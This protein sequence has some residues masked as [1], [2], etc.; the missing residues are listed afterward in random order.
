MR[1][2]K[3]SLSRVSLRQKVK[4][5]LGLEKRRIKK[6]G[7]FDYDY[8]QSQV[9]HKRFLSKDSTI[10]HYLQKGVFSGLNPNA[11]FDSDFYVAVYPEPISIG[12][13][14]FYH[15]I[16]VGRHEQRPCSGSKTFLQE[17][18]LKSMVVIDHGILAY[19]TNAGDRHI[20][21]YLELFKKMGFHVIY[22]PYTFSSADDLKYLDDLTSKGIET[23]V[24]EIKQFMHKWHPRIWEQWLIDN[25]LRFQLAVLSRPHVANAYGSLIQHSLCKPF[26]YFVIDL[27]YLR[28]F[29]SLSS[30][31]SLKTL[32]LVLKM[33]RLERRIC[34]KADHIFT[35]SYVES[36]LIRKK[37][38]PNVSDIPLFL[39]EKTGE[40]IQ[41]SKT[42][43]EFIF[44][45][46]FNHEP[47][48]LGLLW[49]IK[50]IMPRILKKYPHAVFNI[51]GK[52][53]PKKLLEKASENIIFHGFVSD[54]KLAALYLSSRLVV[55]PLL[56]GAGVKGKVLEAIKFGKP[57]VSTSIGV[58]GILGIETVTSP[59]DKP[60]EFADEVCRY[61]KMN[62]SDLQSVARASAQVI[63]NYFSFKAGEIIFQNIIDQQTNPDLTFETIHGLGD[64]DKS[65]Q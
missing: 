2:Y 48:A 61:L 32:V 54:E 4:M 50:R 29:R 24:E 38:N 23:P 56:F 37:F 22:L 51:V 42:G 52:N 45:G 28:L 8:Y 36:D 62:D 11:D 14:P 6:S 44:V 17:T 65:I 63:N 55:A 27:H 57:I 13:N 34:K 59:K 3:I 43:Q 40:D 12:V 16:Q 18:Q 58:E 15:Y 53:P 49:F 39:L 46:S 9:P 5:I 20:L 31:F 33:Y 25:R 7:L 64:N 1:Q 60:N 26:W 35:P 21:N 30:S 19:D 47:N 10:N 41:V